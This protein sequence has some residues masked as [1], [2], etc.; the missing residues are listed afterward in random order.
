MPGDRF[1]SFVGSVSLSGLFLL[2]GWGAGLLMC[3][4]QTFQFERKVTLGQ[5]LQSCVLLA[6]FFLANH[7]YQRTH[8]VRRKRIEILIDMVGGILA[9]SGLAH[10]SFLECTTHGRVSPRMR[11][12]LD[13]ALTDYS[14][15]LE[16][17][18]QVVTYRGGFR[19]DF[20]LDQLKRDRKKYKDLVTESPYP[21]RMPSD[22]IT[23]A[24]KLH[25][26]IRSNLRRVQLELSA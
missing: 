16:E 19:Q 8:D 20:G 17:L 13:S 3:R 4:W 25:T 2:V 6:L 26:R 10:K 24:A 18:E 21:I 23:A 15:A 5:I 7:V 11:R 1:R 12:N 22:R 9:M 14:N